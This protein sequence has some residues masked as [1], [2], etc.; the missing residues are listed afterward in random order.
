MSGDT[1]YASLVQSKQGDCIN[2]SSVAASSLLQH[3]DEHHDQLPSY[4]NMRSANY[5]NI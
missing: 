3:D 1:S 2:E 5:E 4:V